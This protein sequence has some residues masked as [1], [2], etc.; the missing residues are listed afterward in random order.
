MIPIHFK[1]SKRVIILL[2]LLPFIVFLGLYIWGSHSRHRANPSDKLMP[3]FQQIGEGFEEVAIRPDRNG[4]IRLLMDS[5]ASLKRVAISMIFILFGVVLGLFMGV[6][7]VFDYTFNKSF[8]FF[9]KLPALALLPIILIIFGLGESSKIALIVIGVL[10]TIILDTY[11]MVK[12]IPHER[13]LKAMTLNANTAHLVFTVLLPQLFPKI[14]DSIRLNFK[15]VI[16]FLIA[17]EAIS[18]TEGLGYRIFLVRRYL[19]M[20]III[21]Y[22]IWIGILAFLFDS[23]LS[24]LIKKRYPWYNAI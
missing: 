23:A 9:D 13:I 7:K 24:Y 19:A 17:G 6:Y 15:A 14:L 8:I 1:P 4:E 16:L 3:T 22:V 18:A 21:V 20:D 11:S 2:S 10:P 12:S 5:I